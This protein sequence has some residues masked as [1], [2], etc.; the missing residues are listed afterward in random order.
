[1]DTLVNGVVCRAEDTSKDR[2]RLC[3]IH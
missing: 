2:R 1:M 3:W